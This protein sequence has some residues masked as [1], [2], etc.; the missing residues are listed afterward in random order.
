M[1][2]ETKVP[3]PLHAFA[4]SRLGLEVS[5]HATAQLGP[6]PPKRWRRFIDLNLSLAKR[7]LNWVFPQALWEGGKWLISSRKQEPMGSAA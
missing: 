7:L 6:V 4:E 1:K 2:K 5:T 3:P